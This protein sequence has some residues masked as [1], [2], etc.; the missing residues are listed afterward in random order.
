[1]SKEWCESRNVNLKKIVHLQHSTYSGQFDRVST[2]HEKLYCFYHSFESM[3]LM[4]IYVTELA[5]I[6]LFGD[7]GG[8]S[9][10]FLYVSG[11]GIATIVDCFL[12]GN[13]NIFCTDVRHREE[14]FFHK[15]YR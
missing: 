15:M 2:L 14:I 3:I 8:H 5:Q 9:K 12:S 7:I 11:R 1:M 13:S 6:V 4:H 10:T